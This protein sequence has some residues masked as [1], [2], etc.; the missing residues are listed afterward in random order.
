[1]EITI[2]TKENKTADSIAHFIDFYYSLRM[3]HLAS[4]LLAKG[5]S[6]EQINAAVLRAIKVAKSS[7]ID[8]NQHF[9]PVFSGIEQQI[10]RD[11]KLSYLAY[12]MV[13][14][15]ADAELPAVGKWQ[16]QVLEYYME[17]L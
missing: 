12:G 4:D 17:S 14:L 6:P 8:A 5:L 1:M 15:N 3:K 11:C 9:R 2:F 13:L 16:Q 10:I 7:G